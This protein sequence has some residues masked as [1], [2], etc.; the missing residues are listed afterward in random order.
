LEFEDLFV[1]SS[2]AGQSIAVLLRPSAEFTPTGDVVIQWQELLSRACPEQS[3][4]VTRLS[5]S[6]PSDELPARIGSIRLRTLVIPTP[7]AGEALIAAI[8]ERTEPIIVW[9]ERQTVPTED[10]WKDLLSRLEHADIV[11]LRRAY[12]G[13][14]MIAWPIEKVMRG[15][16][17]IAFGDPLSPIKVMR[18]EAVAPISLQ[19]EGAGVHLE[20]AAKGTYLIRLIDELPTRERRAT[21]LSAISS[22]GFARFFL[23]PMLQL[24]ELPAVMTPTGMKPSLGPITSPPKGH[25]SECGS[26]SLGPSTR[27]WGSFWGYRAS[28]AFPRK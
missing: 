14:A 18:R 27:R 23:Q 21:W 15:I 26:S 4:S 10:E 19:M 8:R 6:W 13:L 16:L 9:A 5:A 12:S 3:H 7:D 25:S 11:S 17:G 2:L 1:R 28:S 24:V 20:M 22:E